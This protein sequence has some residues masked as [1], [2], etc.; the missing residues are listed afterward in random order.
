MLLISTEAVTSLEYDSESKANT[1]SS[2][3][4]L[5]TSSF[6]IPPLISISP[7]PIDLP[8][9]YNNIDQLNLIQRKQLIQQYQKQIANIIVQLY[10]LIRGIRV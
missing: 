9:F 7:S 3:L 1:S 8:P 4:P 10:M 6:P 2:F 5:Y